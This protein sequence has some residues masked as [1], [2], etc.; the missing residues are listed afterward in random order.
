MASVG[1][2]LWF[3]FRGDHLLVFRDSDLA[4]PSAEYVEDLDVEV[5]FR[6]E[7]GALEGRACWAAEVAPEAGPPEGMEFRDLRSLFSETSEDLFRM[8]GRA[9]QIVGW[10]ARQCLWPESRRRSA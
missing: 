1:P 2:A 6:R 4:V 7:I 8:A 10:H 5:L 3:L 9:K